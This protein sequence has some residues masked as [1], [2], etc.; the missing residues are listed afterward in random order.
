MTSTPPPDDILYEEAG[1][2]TETFED[3]LPSP[4]ARVLADDRLYGD[5]GT[6]RKPPTTKPPRP[7]PPVKKL[8]FVVL[9]FVL[10]GAAYWLNIQEAAT[11]PYTPPPSQTTIPPATTT[12]S[13]S[14]TP[15]T[16]L[17][18]TPPKLLIT[19]QNESS[20]E[21]CASFI[22]AE[23]TAFEDVLRELPLVATDWI[24]GRIGDRIAVQNISELRNA[25]TRY[26]MSLNATPEITA[27]PPTATAAVTTLA[28]ASFWGQKA[29]TAFN[30]YIQ[31]GD[32]MADRDWDQFQR[33]SQSLRSAREALDG[34][35][36][37]LNATLTVTSTTSTPPTTVSS[38]L[39]STTT[40][41]T[42]T[43]SI[44]E[45]AETCNDLCLIRGYAGGDC[46]KR[47][48]ICDIKGGYIPDN[49]LGFCNLAGTTGYCCCEALPDEGLITSDG[50][51]A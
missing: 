13:S 16:T 21:A 19:F 28:A 10:A 44:P 18:D 39:A 4:D 6:L 20:P 27:C 49:S 31:S 45:E 33:Y 9:V 36:A 38:T 48:S 7:S 46:K 23:V 17:A 35:A 34:V 25:Y 50:E 24:D 5:S 41:L 3:A 42:T 40:S 32:S 51:S 12:S 47:R 1:D 30:A 22:T 8:V 43:T 29:A 14:D 37:E 11:L 26:R 15:E 2:D